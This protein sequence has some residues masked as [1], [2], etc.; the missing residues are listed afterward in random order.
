MASS[1]SLLAF[2]IWFLAD[3]RRGLIFVVL[4]NLVLLHGFA[5]HFS[6]ALVS[7]WRGANWKTGPE[8]AVEGLLSHATFLRDATFLLIFCIDAAA[9]LQTFVKTNF[10]N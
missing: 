9:I 3:D 2:P 5:S 8:D 7:S 10:D 4:L 1:N 6:F